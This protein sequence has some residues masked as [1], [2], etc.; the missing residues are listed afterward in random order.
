V[1]SLL[2]SQGQSPGHTCLLAAQHAQLLASPGTKD[3]DLLFAFLEQTLGT[4]LLGTSFPAQGLVLEVLNLGED[5]R[6]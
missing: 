6:P 4:Q 2:G 5:R 1:H 3:S